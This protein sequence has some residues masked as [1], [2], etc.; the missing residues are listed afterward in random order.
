MKCPK[1][2]AEMTIGELANINTRGKLFWAPE[3]Y[4]KNK[5]LN[6]YTK[7]DVLKNGGVVI[8]FGNGITNN[9]TKGYLCS[10][11]HCLLMNLG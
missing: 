11:C 3:H 8:S 4:F 5:I 2:G 7:K 10:Q 1:C 9:R 6:W